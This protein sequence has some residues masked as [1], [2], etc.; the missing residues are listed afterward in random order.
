M[1]E[2][3]FTDETVPIVGH[4]EEPLQPSYERVRRKHDELQARLSKGK[5]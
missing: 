1:A 2:G 3:G 5:T 4:S